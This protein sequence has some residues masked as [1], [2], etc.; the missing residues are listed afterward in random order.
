MGY[1][2]GPQHRA[3]WLA[4]LA[5]GTELTDDRRDLFFLGRACTSFL[6]CAGAMPSARLSRRPGTDGAGG[7]VQRCT[8]EARRRRKA[9]ALLHAGGRGRGRTRLRVVPRQVLLVGGVCG[10]A[11]GCC[12]CMRARVRAAC[13]RAQGRG[14]RGLG[15]THSLGAR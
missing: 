11:C 15:T 7:G 12:D 14:G 6:S 4:V 8:E 5:I 10:C 9:Q 2:R 13:R 1:E 3:G